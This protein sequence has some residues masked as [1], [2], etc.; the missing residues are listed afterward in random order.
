MTKNA[1]VHDAVIS[2]ARILSRVSGRTVYLSLINP[3]KP[4]C[5]HRIQIK[6]Q[7][8]RSHKLNN[9]QIK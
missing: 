3:S 7:H 4:D 9:Q 5:S 8:Y 6:N 1:Y 2:V